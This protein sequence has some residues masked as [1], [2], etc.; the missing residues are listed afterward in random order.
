[1]WVSEYGH[2][3]EFD[4]SGKATCEESGQEYLLENDEV[5]RIA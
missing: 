1:G 2:R 4:E 5:T 3:L